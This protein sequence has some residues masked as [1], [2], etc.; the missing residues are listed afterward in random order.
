MN[1]VSLS[2]R[3]CGSSSTH[4][5]CDLGVS[6]LANSFLTQN[7][8][9]Q[10]EPF[11]P[12]HAY[13]CA[14]CFLVQLQDFEPPENIFRDYAYFSSCSDSW[15][16]HCEQYSNIVI[17]RF[18]LTSDSLVVEVASNDG[19]MLQYFT[20][21]NIRVLGV[22]PADNVAQVAIESGIETVI[23]FFDHN[24][25]VE[26]S[27]QGKSAD[28]LIA[29]NVLAHVPEINSFVKGISSIL[30]PGGVATIEFPH[31]MNLINHVQFD[32]IYHEHFSY[33]SLFTAK[34]IFNKHGLEVF[35]VEELPTH[36]GSLRVYLKHMN[37]NNLATS[38]SVVRIIE[39]EIARG[40]NELSTY[41]QFVDRV[42]YVK[43]C[44]LKFLIS[45]KE[46]NKK[47]VAYGAAAKGNTLLN[48]SGIKT[49]YIDYVV[50]VNPKKQN[51]YLPGSHIPVFDVK[52]I[53][54]TKPDYVLILPWNISTEIT[55]KIAFIEAW[56]GK[57]VT[58]IPEVEI[59]P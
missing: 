54:E 39:K 15:L 29:N 41:L 5:F 16:K 6:P 11:Y 21:N 43:N 10:M 38:D 49:D 26:L 13:V 56:G 28:L 42:N 37:N 12:L 58:P 44:L 7:Q 3:F 31:L 8:L 32:T 59:F 17:D 2:C 46:N 14:E 57:F 52:R 35:D 40:I 22:E 45:A 47:V 19:Y 4:S 48:Y 25:A 9:N 55:Q 30:Q 34:K 20:R 50:D 23:E 36:G 51:K 27:S 24:L 1:S 53:A 18:G 33:F